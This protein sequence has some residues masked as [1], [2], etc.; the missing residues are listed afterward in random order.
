[1]QDQVSCLQLLLER[2][3]E[4]GEVV[5][6]AASGMH[7]FLHLSLCVDIWE[8]VRYWGER[9]VCDKGLLGRGVQH[10]SCE[11]WRGKEQRDWKL[12]T[13][14]E[15]RSC[16][17]SCL[18]PLC[19]CIHMYTHTHTMPYICYDTHAHTSGL[20]VNWCTVFLSLPVLW[21]SWRKALHPLTHDWGQTRESWRNRTS[22]ELMR[23]RYVL[24]IVWNVYY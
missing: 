17:V 12:Q 8:C 9:A 6:F 18:L 14:V 13:V 16:Q 3:A 2:E 1:M 15:G 5:I 11:E 7:P 10:C 22:T 24:N 19:M 23:K 20:V 21:M 4:K